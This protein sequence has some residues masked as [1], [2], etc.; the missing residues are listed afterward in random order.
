MR[1]STSLII[2]SALIFQAAALGVFT[3]AAAAKSVADGVHY[4]AGGFDTSAQSSTGPYFPAVDVK[5]A[6]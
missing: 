2:L 3:T 6:D 4:L 5:S 1:P